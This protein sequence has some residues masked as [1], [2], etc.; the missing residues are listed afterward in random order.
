VLVCVLF[1]ASSRVISFYNK[2]S[3]GE[4]QKVSF[5]NDL[6]KKVFHGSFHKVE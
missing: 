2:D 4:I 3:R 5:D 1:S 6:V